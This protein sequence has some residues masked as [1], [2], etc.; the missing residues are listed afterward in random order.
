MS[1]RYGDDVLRD[2]A[3]TIMEATTQTQ[4][5]AQLGRKL[6]NLKILS[7]LIAHELHAQ[8]GT[9]QVNLSREEVGEIQTCLDLFIEEVSRKQ[10]Q[11]SGVTTSVEPTLVAARNN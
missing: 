6:A 3:T 2:G 4:F 1:P 9:K 5:T 11:M 8:Q 7:R 10:G